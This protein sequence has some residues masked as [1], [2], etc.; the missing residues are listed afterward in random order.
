MIEFEIDGHKVSVPPGGTVMDGA[1]ELG[2]HIPHFCYHRKL[3]VAANCRMCLVDVEKSP[4]PLPACATPATPGMIVRTASDKAREAQ[5]SVMEFLL[6]NHPLDCPICDQGG[7]CQLQDLAVGYGKPAS[8][9]REE[10]RVVF[11][12]NLGPLVSAAEMNRCIHCT[13]CVRFGQ[14]IA[15]I[16]ELGMAGHGEHSEIMPFVGQAVESEL[17]GNMID[18]CPV[19]ALTSKPFRYMARTW[20][21][22]RRKSVAPHDSLGSNIVVQVKR[23][24]VVRVV[25]LENDAV[26]ECW[27]SDRDRFSYEGL[28]SADRLTRPMV[29]EGDQWTEVSWTEALTQAASALSAV[30]REQGAEAIAALASGSASAEELYLLGK[31]VRGLGSQSVDFRTRQADFSADA[32]RDR[33]PWLGMPVADL[34]RL[35]RV[36]LVGSFL[37]QDHPLLAVRLR[38]AVSRGAHLSVVHATDE[39]LLMRVQQRSVIAPSRW[40]DHL[41]RI[42]VAVSQL[43]GVP[44]GAGLTAPAGEPGADASAIA[45]DLASGERVGLFLGNAG[46]QHPQAAALRAWLT[47]IAQALGGRCGVLGE[48][49]NSVGGYLADALPGPGGLNARTM[50]EQPRAAY[51][52]WGLEPNLDVADAGATLAA[53]KQAQHVIACSTV[54]SDTLR[55]HASIILPI[56]AF[57]ETFG[58]YVNCEGRVQSAQGVVPPPGEAR[59][60]WKVLR[61]LGGELGLEGFDY[62]SP[63]GVRADAL[64]E[65]ARRSLSNDLPGLTAAAGAG[66]PGVERIADV[67]LYQVDA[68]VRRAP[69][70]QATAAASRPSLRANAA[71]LQSLGLGQG[72]VARVRQGGSYIHIACELDATVADATVRIA[73]AHPATAGLGNPFGPLTV[74]RF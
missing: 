16:M 14:E 37:R 63:E 18:V 13:R 60:G 28:R 53:L 66:T 59:P 67:P 73:S 69:S 39:K 58:T 46:A 29:R 68:I 31:L 43:R 9:Y 26:N 17:S 27:I 32:L 7:E 65:P 40:L 41:A 54:L 45:A 22:S 33:A 61:V 62:D 35:D 24:E 4:K 25:P 11:A 34:E 10:K 1:N 8:R 48:A 3:S 2:I 23:D 20:E 21:L 5:A 55:A 6:I 44:L 12:K 15:G 57:A 38:K 74:E 64:P 49:A 36:L 71:T 51:L 19:G 42:G 50:F 56:A 70:L 52:I 47:W 30:R 72:A